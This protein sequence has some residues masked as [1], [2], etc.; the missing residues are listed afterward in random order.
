MIGSP[1]IA[2]ASAEYVRLAAEAC[3]PRTII[4]PLIAIG[5]TLAMSDDE[6]FCLVGPDGSTSLGSAPG[7]HADVP[8]GREKHD[9]TGRA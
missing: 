2:G 6:E 8:R 1:L 3:S 4:G 5:S 7:T 9:R